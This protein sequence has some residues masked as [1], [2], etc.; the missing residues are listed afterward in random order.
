MRRSLA[1]WLVLFTTFPVAAAD[2]PAEPTVD[3]AGPYE[4]GLREQRST[5][6]LVVRDAKTWEAW[7]S[8]LPTLV[9]GNVR[10]LDTPNDDPVLKAKIDWTKSSV[11]VVTGA[12]SPTITRVTTTADGTRVEYTVESTFE[13]RPS[14]WGAY[15]ARVV[16]R[17]GAKVEFR[18][19]KQAPR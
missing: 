13:A 11:V 10:K 12:D 8:R 17:T 7:K 16:P 14:H 3:Y 15:A 4:F 2:P 5:R 18:R 9:A 1:A 6:G 19:V